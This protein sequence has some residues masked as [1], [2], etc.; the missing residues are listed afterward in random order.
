MASNIVVER[1]D[2]TLLWIFR[3]E[4]HDVGVFGREMRP[5]VDVM[6]LGASE[7]IWLSLEENPIAIYDFWMEG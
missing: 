2:G 7:R 5:F 1:R 3:G 4:I 6:F